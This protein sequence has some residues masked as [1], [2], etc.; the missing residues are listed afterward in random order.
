MSDDTGAVRMEKPGEVL[1]KNKAHFD[2]MHADH[3]RCAPRVTRA[4]PARIRVAPMPPCP[5]LPRCRCRGA[6]GPHSHRAAVLTRPR[7]RRRP[8]YHEPTTPTSVDEVGVA[9]SQE[10]EMTGRLHDAMVENSKKS[11]ANLAAAA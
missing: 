4:A 2:Q 5:A 3:L 7:V 1:V 6:S 10:E 9:Y 11:Q 8:S